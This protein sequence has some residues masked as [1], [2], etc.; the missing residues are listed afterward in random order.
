[1]YVQA[2]DRQGLF[3]R[4]AP[5]L[6]AIGVAFTLTPLQPYDGN[7]NHILF[8][9]AIA[10]AIVVAVAFLPWQR[11]PR[12]AQSVPA[13][14]FFGVV[15]LLSEAGGGATSAYGPLVFLP[16]VW[17]ALYGERW[18]LVLALG[19][20]TATFFGPLVLAGGPAYA[21]TEWGWAL[22]AL[23][24]AALV[25]ITVQGLVRRLRWRAEESSQQ[26][27]ALRRSEEEAQLLMANMA[28]VTQ[29]TREVARTTDIAAARAAV[30]AAAREIAGA[31]FAVLLET[32]GTGLVETASSGFELDP[33]LEV[34]VGEEP[35]GAAAAFVSRQPYF[36]DDVRNQE[37]V[38]SR[39]V[40]AT[41][42]VSMHFEP[43]L[44]ERDAVG[45][46]VVGWDEPIDGLSERVAAAVRTIAAEAAIALERAALLEQLQMS[47]H[48]DDLT[49]LPNRRAWEEQLPREL[50]RARRERQSVCV[51]M[52]DLDH[53]KD[54]NDREGHQA[55]DRLLKLC[56][57]AWS[58]QLRA[59]DVL[60]R[61]G[62]EEFSL[63]L[64]G[65]TIADAR[66][67][68]ERLR[69]MTPERQTLSGGIA[70][71]DDEEPAAA[72]VGRADSALYEAK[73]AGRN[74]VVSAAG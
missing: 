22:A 55:G 38:A 57:A 4:A 31:S 9:V 39:V 15:V 10:S 44:G 72:L 17:V 7:P 68:V 1:M 48:T 18:E 28:A 71:W 66:V 16:V 40:E 67:L 8:A 47:A 53:F 51:V 59:T 26:A 24:V 3:A 14:G 34:S 43:V 49:G 46:L 20:V 23:L 25:G 74:R 54:F 29:L 42:V 37:T 33:Q 62:G 35:S 30:C 58:S 41:G 6:L 70:A 61:Y 65:C 56:A 5:F 19:G 50:A 52:L 13:L 69:E 21:G 27:D 2:F 36:V 60:A 63:L 64:P 11:L 32:T 73:R 12:Y 45:V